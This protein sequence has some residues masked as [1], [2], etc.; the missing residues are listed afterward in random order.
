M[1]GYD[2]QQ[3]TFNYLL[4][5]SINEK[6]WDITGDRI[7]RL[8]SGSFRTKQLADNGQHQHRRH[9]RHKERV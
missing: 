4:L 8:V 3:I 5:K 1:L 9:S 2:E 7:I 6:S